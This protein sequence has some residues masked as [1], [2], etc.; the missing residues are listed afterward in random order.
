MMAASLVFAPGGKVVAETVPGVVIDHSPKTS[1]IYIGS[2]SLA[3]WTNGD[4]IAT[5]DDFGPNST[6]A[7]T[8]VFTSHDR[9]RTWTKTCEID[10]QYWSTL[11]MHR[12]ALYLIGTSREYGAVVIRRSTDGGRSWT[13]PRDSASGLLLP[14]PKHHCAP[15]PVIVHNGRIWRAMEDAQGP[16]RWAAFFRA[17]MMSAPERSD[18]LNAANWT[19]SN[20]LGGDT[21]WLDGKFGGWLEGNAVVAPDGKI[22]DLLRCDMLAPRERAAIVRISGDG[23][24]A[25]FDPADGFVDLPGGA[26]KFT[27][28]FDTRSKLYWSMTNVIATKDVSYRPGVVRNT[29]AL[30]SSPDLRRWTVRRELLHHETPARFGF[31]YVDWQFDGPDLIAVVRTAFDDETGGA[32]SYH[33]ANY[34]IFLRVPDFR[35]ASSE[36]GQP[37]D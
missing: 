27:V 24:Q 6:L 20:R 33:D 2:P 5:H 34:V 3:V 21:G 4:Y 36:P 29:L 7:K 35:A 30:I 32:H 1:G 26:K 22:V 19:S 10:G 28:R 18:L 8:T 14:D 13:E 25:T 9:G 11:F 23:R 37:A 15:V 17:F 16:G 31:Q 12:G